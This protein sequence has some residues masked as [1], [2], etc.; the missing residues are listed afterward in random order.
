MQ[1]IIIF[2]HQGAFAVTDLA[3]RLSRRA[4]L[5]AAFALSLAPL[6]AGPALAAEEVNVYSARHYDT[7]EAL[8]AHF[9]KATGIRVNRIE[10]DADKLMERMRTEGV[11]SP[12]DVF[13]AVDAGRLWRAQAAGLLQPLKSPVL[14]AAVPANLRAP[15]GE[16]FGLSK[17]VRIIVYNKAKV[18]PEEIKGYE[19]LA[20]PKW[21]GRV[22]VR[23]STHIYNQSLTGALIAALG[24]TGAESW[25]RGLV[26]NFARSPRGGDTDQIRAVAAGEGDVALVNHYY[27]AHLIRSAK[28]EDKAAVEKIDMVFPDQS[29]RGAHVNISG[30]GLARHAP[31]RANA[32]KLLE[33]FVSPEAQAI[34]AEGNAEYPAVKGARLSPILAGWGEFREDTVNAAVFGR[35][36]EAALKLMD[37]AGWK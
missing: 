4:L 29:G 19:N 8:Y 11:N 22:L 23:S 34:F 7:D 10:A 37:R 25:A 35:N 3:N 15:D 24:E 26:A 2:L 31:N 36:N 12:A 9:T 13:V 1:I 5:R 20:D 32:I 18:R 21:K 14:E 33:Y 17:R 30:A 28:P 16:W 27:L 6:L